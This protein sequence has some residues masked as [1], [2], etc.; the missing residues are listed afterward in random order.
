MAAASTSIQ[1][2]KFSTEA[3]H[4]LGEYGLLPADARV[5][6]L[7]GEIVELSPINSPHSGTINRLQKI[8]EKLLGKT[9]IIANQNPIQLGKYSEP[10]PD[11]AVLLWR[12][13][14]YFDKHPVPKEVAFPVEV[15]DSTLEK[16]RE[17]KLPLYAQANIPEVWIVNLK[18]K[19]LEVYT[20]PSE[21]TYTQTKVYQVGD[22]LVGTLV[23]TLKFDQIL[24]K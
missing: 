12:D 18:A 17:L 20:L 19:Q 8:L 15:A 5:E 3:Y 13:D 16:D 6:L 2:F 24:P 11:L 21:S 7:D 1:R 9:H 10:E 4:Q 14:F 22:L 23:P